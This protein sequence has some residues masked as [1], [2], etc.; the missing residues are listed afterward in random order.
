MDYTFAADAQHPHLGGNIKEGDPFT[1]A[2]TTWRYLCERFAL[3]TLLDLGSGL[4][5]SAHFFSQR[6]VQVIAVDGL[7][8]NVDNAIVP[9][10]LHDLTHAPFRC[11]VDMVY[12]V[13]VVE[14]I[15]EQFMPNLLTTFQSAKFI[16]MSHADPDQP[17]YHH[18]NC[19]SDA[20]WVEQLTAAGFHLLP[21]DTQRVRNAANTDGAYHIS[22]SGLVFA[23]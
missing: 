6:G 16:T 21:E 15:A 1:F 7:E 18:V 17:G 3:R 2:P 23:R 9:T 12:C 22:R 8:E 5:Y 13:E 4:G 11:R 14:H 20:Y 10:V 19:K